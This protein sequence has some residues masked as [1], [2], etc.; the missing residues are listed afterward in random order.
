M[1]YFDTQNVPSFVYAGGSEGQDFIFMK[2]V[3]NVWTTVD[4][5]TQ[6]ANGELI[7]MVDSNGIPYSSFPDPENS[8]RLCVEKYTDSAWS[9][10]GCT[11]KGYG[12]RTL[13]VTTKGPVIR[14]LEDLGGGVTHRIQLKPSGSSWVYV[15]D[16]AGI[17]GVVG[18]DSNN[19]MIIRED[20][21][22]RMLS[23][24]PELDSTYQWYRNG[25]EISG[26]NDTTYI[27]TPE[28]AGKTITFGVTPKSTELTGKEVISNEIS[29]P[30]AESGNVRPKQS[31]GSRPVVK[32]TTTT[33]TTTTTASPSTITRTL[34][35]GMTGEDVKALQIYLNTHGYPIATTGNG[36]LHNETTYFG[37]KTK[38]AVIKFQKANG[39]TPDGVVGAKTRALMK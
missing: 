2:L 34:K 3:D 32:P 6:G 14:S 24:D 5:L 1:A 25:S 16:S 22:V 37:L 28:D 12:N 18:F 30:A 15:L 38:A 35:L 27:T 17:G 4:T 39:L 9:T 21:T 29:I 7:T 19:V 13:A 36:S 20:Q 11:I 33:P 23:S 31:S 26:A 10:I 8:S